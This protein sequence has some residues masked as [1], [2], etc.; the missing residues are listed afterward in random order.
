MQFSSEK[1]QNGQYAYKKSSILVIWEL[2]IK[3]Y[4]EGSIS[5]MAK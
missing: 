3:S 1:I 4:W 5:K 2:Q